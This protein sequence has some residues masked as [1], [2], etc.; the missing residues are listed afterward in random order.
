MR[1]DTF[2]QL[3]I[4]QL[5]LGNLKDDSTNRVTV[6]KLINLCCWFFKL[7]HWTNRV[8]ISKI[9]NDTET[10]WAEAGNVSR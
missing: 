1:T 6:T 3:D 9:Q 8:K 4:L 7:T 2:N 10:K 5:I